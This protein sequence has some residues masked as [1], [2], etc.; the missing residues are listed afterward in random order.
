MP[1]PLADLMQNV[2][3]YFHMNRFSLDILLL[4]LR[5]DPSPLCDPIYYN[6]ST[7]TLVL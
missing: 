3:K 6:L 2:T 7:L 4:H 1:Y 5:Y